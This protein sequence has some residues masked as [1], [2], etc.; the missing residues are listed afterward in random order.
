MRRACAAPRKRQPRRAA[1]S[2]WGGLGRRWL[3]EWCPLPARGS[4]PERADPSEPAGYLS[5]EWARTRCGVDGRPVP[6]PGLFRLPSTRCTWAGAGAA[7]PPPSRTCA[8]RFGLAHLPRRSP[9]ASTPQ[10]EDGFPLGP[11]SR[12][13]PTGLA[14]TAGFLADLGPHRVPAGGARARAGARP[15]VTCVRAQ[16]P[17]R[18][19]LLPRAEGGG[20]KALG[21]VEDQ[22]TN[23]ELMHSALISSSSKLAVFP[24]RHPVTSS[25]REI[26]WSTSR[27]AMVNAGHGPSY[28]TQGWADAGRLEESGRPLHR[29][30][31]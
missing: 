1:A 7:Q 10:C 24:G 31:S 18:T 30:K 19:A 23:L 16:P 20:S 25:R 2:F 15:G 17:T 29:K 3:L 8:R 13:V 5:R 28:R 27:S 12:V 26:I 6:T 11:G 4:P 22:A 14:H 21:W 9:P